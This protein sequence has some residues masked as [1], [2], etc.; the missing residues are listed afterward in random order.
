MAAPMSRFSQRIRDE[1]NRKFIGKRTL[2]ARRIHLA[3]PSSQKI[4]AKYDD[5]NKRYKTPNGEWLAVVGLE[6]HAQVSSRS[7]LFSGS[8]VKFLAPPN[9]LVSFFDASLP[10]TLPAL[11]KSCVEAGVLTALALSCHINKKS[12]FDR[13]HYFYADLPAGYQ[14][15]QQRLPLAVDGQINFAIFDWKGKKA[16]SQHTVRI[17]QIQLEHDSGKSLHDDDNRMSLVDLNRTGVGLMELVSEPDLHTGQEA[18]AMVSEL[19]RILQCLGTCDGKMEEGSMRVDANVSVNRPGD[20]WG[21][22]SEVKNINSMRFVK[23][24][25]D[26]E[27]QRQIELLENGGEVLPETRAYDLKSGGTISMRDKEGKQD[28]RFMPEPNLPPLIVYDNKSIESATNVKSAVNIDELRQCLPELPEAQ[29]QRLVKDY[30]IK[31][32]SAI[33]LVNED[34]LAEYFEAILTEKPGRDGQKVANWITTTLLQEL[35][36]ADIPVSQSPMKPSTLGE[37]LDCVSDGTISINNAKKL[38]EVIFQGERRPV[39]EIIEANNWAQITDRNQIEELCQQVLEENPLLVKKY[40]AGNTKLINA[41]MGSLQKKT[42]GRIE[43]GTTL[44]ILKNK[45]NR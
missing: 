38:V 16:P 44:D 35:H 1:L 26:F 30:G 40:K 28:Y 3:S 4:Y 39:K 21:T 8:E 31:L 27:I 34:D 29:R 24:A 32:E 45:L 19:R 6:I 42:Q 12:L 11:N 2:F 10:G 36:Q 23:T 43:P 37:L 5:K 25:V 41:L 14:I 13:K 9:S 22:R 17:K 15:T 7:K 20:P 18:G 33:K